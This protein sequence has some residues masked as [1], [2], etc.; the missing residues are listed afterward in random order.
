MSTHEQFCRRLLAKWCEHKAKQERALIGR[1]RRAYREPTLAKLTNQYADTLEAAAKL[2]D[3]LRAE[4][5]G[6]Y[7]RTTLAPGDLPTRH[8]P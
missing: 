3:D 7:G 6:N 1:C 2:F 8:E 4:I 5:E